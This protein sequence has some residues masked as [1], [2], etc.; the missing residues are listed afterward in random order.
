[1]M[2]GI[3]LGLV[4]T[5]PANSGKENNRSNLAQHNGDN[6]G[7]PSATVINNQTCSPNK[8]SGDTQPPH[9]YAS[10][11]WWLCILGLPTLIFI[12]WQAKATAD[13]AKATQESARATAEQSE[14]MMA[15]E[16]AKL[17][18]I[19]PP[20]DPT[21]QGMVIED[22]DGAQSVPLNL[23]IDI[24][25]DGET[26]AFNVTA[27]G[28]IR[29][30]HIEVGQVWPSHGERL[31]IPKVIR[32]ANAKKPVRLSLSQYEF[33]TDILVSRSD[34]EDVKKGNKPL[35]V[36]GTI[37]YEDVFGKPHRTP[38]WHTWEVITDDGNWGDESRWTD[39]SSAS[40]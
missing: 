31:K 22:V 8:E 17:S 29:M 7:S 19:F 21:E 36:I 27:S 11:E 20:N 6:N 1:M 15:R 32:R 35:H 9:W 13:A 24:I 5:P 37:F 38:F 40:D 14:N 12:G 26:K 30:E 34:W 25:N 28:Y 2:L 39:H 33:M 16:R 10:P 23:F 3:L 18:V 4:T